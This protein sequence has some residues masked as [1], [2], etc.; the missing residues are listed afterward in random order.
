MRLIRLSFQENPASAAAFYM[1]ECC[2]DPLKTL[3]IT[4]SARFKSYFATLSLNLHRKDDLISPDLTTAGELVRST[5]ASLGKPLATEMERLSM[6]SSAFK[7]TKAIEKLFAFSLPLRFEP[8]SSTASAL[9][10][11]FD[12]IN[13]EEADIDAAGLAESLTEKSAQLAHYFETF[14]LLYNNYSSIQKERKLYDESFLI[15]EVRQD[16]ILKSMSRYE[17]VLLVSPLSLTHFERRIFDTVDERLH[18]LYQDT[19]EYDFSNI[20]SYRSKG[21]GHQNDR[22]ISFGSQHPVHQAEKAQSISTRSPSLFF[23][24]PSRMAE[25]ATVLSLIKDEIEA[26]IPYHD[27]AVLNI[28]PR[29]CEMLYDSFCSL[30]IPVNYSKGR[31]L[32]KSSVYALLNL[33]KRF[34]DSRLDSRLFLEILKDELFAELTG[35]KEL[36]ADYKKIKQEIHKRRIFRLTSFDSEFIAHDENKKEAFALFKR[37]YESKSFDTLYERL[38]TLLFSVGTRKTYEFY[39]AK[40][41]LLSSVLELRDLIMEFAETPF[42]ILLHHLKTKNVP[43]LG[44]YGEGIQIIGILET[45]GIRFKSVIVPSFNEGFF[46]ARTENDMFLTQEMRKRLGLSTLFDRE[47]L[48]FYYLKRIIDTAEHSY[49]L[50]IIDNT[51]Q[52][53]VRSRYYYLFT[54]MGAGVDQ[55]RARCLFPVRTASVPV[56]PREISQPVLRS[57]RREYS[58][59]DIDRLKRCETQYYIAKVLGIEQQEVLTD[60]IEMDLVGRRVHT[61]FQEMYKE[62]DFDSRLPD[63]DELDALFIDLFERLFRDGLFCT[64]EE[65][66]LKRVLKNNLAEALGRDFERFQSGYRVCSRFI[67]EEFSAHIGPPENGFTLKGRIDRIDRSPRGGYIIIDYKTGTIPERSAHFEG[68]GYRE[69]QLGFY[70]LLFQKSYPDRKIEGLGYF[71]LSNQRDIVTLIEGENIEPYLAGF[72]SSLIDF[73]DRFNAKTELSLTVDPLNCRYCPYSAISRIYEK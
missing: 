44:T 21:A 27:I 11:I 16:D 37:I 17:S 46:P 65:A 49:F 22:T 3:V 28:D 10:S 12:E 68:K 36:D 73:L 70:G 2:L 25:V 53:D 8:F 30:G 41:I 34:F 57:P 29:F 31:A 40:N 69:V 38:N 55:G 26:G 63:R 45:R 14:K 51:G 48:E 47:D 64:K 67:E 52:I 72:E 62:I 33:V 24:V 19:D 56:P 18:V 58:R 4:P 61:L 50:S 9:L 5:I 42:E 59:L 13:R 23:E 71:D 54:H 32:K 6:F 20:L 7:S 66:L 60:T 15:R 1:K 43:A 39:V 35:Y